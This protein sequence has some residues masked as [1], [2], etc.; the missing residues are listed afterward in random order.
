MQIF[1]LLS[2]DR[3]LLSRDRDFMD[4]DA[5]L[6]AD[7]AQPAQHFVIWGPS[8]PHRR[9]HINCGASFGTLWSIVAKIVG[10]PV[11]NGWKDHSFLH[12]FIHTLINATL[13]PRIR[14]P[15]GT[16]IGLGPGDIVLDGDPAPP[17]G[18]GTGAPTISAHVCYGQVV[19]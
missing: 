9:G 12:S 10:A 11:P 13:C 2:R 18:R 19:E 15:L 17:K 8:S 4:Y 3:D 16:Q 1:F 6:E 14:M 7:W 5:T